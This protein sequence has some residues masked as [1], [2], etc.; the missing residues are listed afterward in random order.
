MNANA[1]KKAFGSDYPEALLF[2]GVRMPLALE[3]RFT[4]YYHTE[5]AGT[6]GHTVSRF[7]DG[8]A[9]ITAEQLKGEWPAWTSDQRL[10]FCGACVWLYQ[11]SDF[12][13]MLRFVML[14][15]GPEEWTCIAQP[16]ASNLPRD[17]AF[18]FMRDALSA[19]GVG[20]SANIIQAVAITKH[21]EAQET[22]RKHLQVVWAHPDMWHANAWLNQVAFEAVVCVQ[23][24]LE[25]ESP[26]ADFED[27]VR[28]LSEHAC[29]GNQD[30]CRRFLSK[31]YSWLTESRE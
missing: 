10:D 30:S 12:G 31:H 14:N 3:T 13:E 5:Q 29:Q 24:L 9:S 27:K 25:L 22:L 15:G 11:Q 17:E 23:Y 16:V 20:R 18:R 28:R 6:G 19:V 8:S 2:E 7:S 1:L 26:P 4:R 21:P